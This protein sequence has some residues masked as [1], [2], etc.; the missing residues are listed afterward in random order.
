LRQLLCGRETVT[1]TYLPRGTVS[2]MKGI[3]VSLVNVVDTTGQS[4]VV[5]HKQLDGHWRTNPH[6]GWQSIWNDCLYRYHVVLSFS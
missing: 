4:C 1:A 3:G 6:F 5:S 2:H